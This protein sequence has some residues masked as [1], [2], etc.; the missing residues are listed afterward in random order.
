MTET[1][2]QFADPAQ[3][4]N[5]LKQH[6]DTS[7][8][9]WLRLAKKGAA[10]PTVTYEQ[11]LQGALCYGWIDG[12]KQAESEHFWLQRFTRR[13]PKSMWSQLNRDRVDVLIAAGKMQLAGMQ[14][15]DKAKKDGRWE[16]AYPSAGSATVPDDLQ[17]ALNANPDA[18]AFF[19]TL[20]GN[21][22]YAILFRIQT[23]RKP[24][25]RARKIREFVDMLSR[26]MT[27]HP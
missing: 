3:W 2:L 23:A 9:V 27:L 16:A 15:I 1:P 25:T 26:G 18:R 11:A 4:E 24:E 22:R 7:T 5:W 13:T 10:Q 8:G 12:K 20:R 14:E 6:H 17:A 19:A 21:N